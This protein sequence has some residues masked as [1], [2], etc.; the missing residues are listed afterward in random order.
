MFINADREYAEGKNQ[1]KLR[2]EDVEKTDFVF[3]N[4]ARDPEI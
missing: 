3:S 2:P 4:I 1:N